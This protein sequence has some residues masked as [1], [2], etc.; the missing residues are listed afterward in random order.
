MKRECEDAAESEY[1]A[2]GF[3]TSGKDGVIAPHSLEKAL[4]NDDN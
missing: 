3:Q 2:E 4:M 1:A